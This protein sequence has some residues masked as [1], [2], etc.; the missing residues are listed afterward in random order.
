MHSQDEKGT[1]ILALVCAF[2]VFPFVA[3]VGGW[4]FAPIFREPNR[5]RYAMPD[6]LQISMIG[7]ATGVVAALLISAILMGVRHFWHRSRPPVGFEETP[8]P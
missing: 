4:I 8:E 5:D 6:D 7:G 3:G 2:A 1:D